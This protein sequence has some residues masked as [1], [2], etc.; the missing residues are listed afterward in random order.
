MARSIN[1]VDPDIS[2]TEEETTTKPNIMTALREELKKKVQNEPVTLKVIS[3]DDVAI[4]FNTNIEAGLVQ[5]WRKRS[6]DKSM[7]DGFD[8]VKFACI[9]IANQAEVVIHKGKE[10]VGNNGEYIS[11]KN[12]ELL[13][14]LGTDRAVDA[15][16]TMYGVDGHILQTAEKIFVAAGYDADESDIENDPF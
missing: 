2:S 1:A 4:R 7:P 13:E 5:Q 15:V 6:S 8:P 12:N 3:R 10:A 9:V 11:F 16:R 14:M